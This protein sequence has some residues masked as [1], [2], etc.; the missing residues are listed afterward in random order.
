M[1]GPG[2]ECYLSNVAS[3]LLHPMRHYKSQPQ[4]EIVLLILGIPWTHASTQGRGLGR[5]GAR[6]EADE[7][8]VLGVGA[9]HKAAEVALQVDQDVAPADVVA[10]NDTWAPRASFSPALLRSAAGGARDEAGLCAG[11]ALP[12]APDQAA[13]LL[14]RLAWPHSV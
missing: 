11:T 4:A 13:L 10:H 7:G 5:Q 9:R 8:G 1:G 2:E 14:M 12:V 3:P 6:D